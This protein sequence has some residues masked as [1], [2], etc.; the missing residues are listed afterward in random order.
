M[1][2]LPQINCTLSLSA[3]NTEMKHQTV[4]AFFIEFHQDFIGDS[5]HKLQPSGSTMFSP[6][7]I[8]LSI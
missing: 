5:A 3:V 1:K 2:H 8:H 6:T 4:S 7:L